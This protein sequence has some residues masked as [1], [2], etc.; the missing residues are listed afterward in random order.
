MIYCIGF[1]GLENLKLRS[2]QNLFKPFINSGK[3]SLKWNFLRFQ[4]NAY[5]GEKIKK[6]KYFILL[7]ILLL[8]TQINGD[9]AQFTEVYEL[10]EDIGVGS[11]SVCKRCIHRATN[12]EFAVKVLPESKSFVHSIYL[13]IQYAYLYIIYINLNYRLTDRHF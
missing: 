7:S 13:Y 1:G 9:S 2:A 6:W 12:M 11:Y 5:L 3:T 8:K 4:I 10:K